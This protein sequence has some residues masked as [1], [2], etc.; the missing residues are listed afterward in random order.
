MLPLLLASPGGASARLAPPRLP[1]LAC[2][3]L[4]RCRRA[5]SSSQSAECRAVG[6]D[7]DGPEQ[8]GGQS[9]MLVPR[10]RA[11]V[12]GRQ[13]PAAPL[14]EVGQGG[15]PHSSSGAISSEA[16]HYR[17]PVV[18]NGDSSTAGNG[19]HAT[20][21]AS[22]LHAATTTVVARNY[23]RRPAVPVSVVP[24][25]APQPQPPPGQ[26]HVNAN[27]ASPPPPKRQRQDAAGRG[28]SGTGSSGTPGGALRP[29]G[30]GNTSV[31]GGEALPCGQPQPSG[32][33]PGGQASADGSGG[34]LEG[35]SASSA[36]RVAFSTAPGLATHQ[37]QEPGGR[38]P[39]QAGPAAR[40]RTWPHAGSAI[41][42]PHLALQAAGGAGPEAA[43]AAPG[44]GVLAAAAASAGAA[45]AAVAAVGVAHGNVRQSQSRAANPPG[46]VSGRAA[47][48]PRHAGASGVRAP[49]HAGT[50]L[51]DMAQLVEEQ[52]HKW[53]A[54][55][56][57]A[58]LNKVGG[59][60][61]AAM[62]FGFKIQIWGAQT[63]R[64]CPAARLCTHRVLYCILGPAA[65][66][67]GTPPLLHHI[68]LPLACRHACF[69]AT[70]MT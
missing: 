7:A 32:R 60:G 12:P 38:V 23:R 49:M 31:S 11:A 29:A 10:R 65:A 54:A 24:P 63:C 1:P 41:G 5:P 34:R 36:G 64:G 66:T 67:N 42:T 25:S 16:A 57:S 26:Q 18:V 55:G 9:R 37:R 2:R 43:A 40:S 22:S 21:T 14:V 50:T 56:L 4:L 48:P 20:A 30:L 27:A 8:G 59:A 68:Q 15:G 17:R 3:C 13:A 6:S 44:V 70:C 69:V 46:G 58:A 45:D 51:Q 62:V 61:D 52:A 47:G 33:R 28:S 53:H 39:A 19:T 35:S